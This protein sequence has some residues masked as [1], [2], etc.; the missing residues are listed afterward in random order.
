MN[1]VEYNK[2][3]TQVL[4]QYNILKKSF[5]EEEILCNYIG[6]FSQDIL[7]S[8]ISLTEHALV[9]SAA[10]KTVKNRL[11]NIIIECV[12]NIIFHNNNLPDNSQLAFIIVTSDD[13]GFKVYAT[14]TIL[15]NKITD[16][17]DKV[18]VLMKEKKESLMSLISKKMKNP[19][20]I[21]KGHGRIGLMTILTKSGKN[22]QYIIDKLSEN[23]A[24]FQLKINVQF[25]DYN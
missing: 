3:E 20:A 5:G 8:I 1:K 12:Q 24:L 15:N 25:K 6:K 14:N 16:L 23:Y 10:P 19:E 17:Q 18:E 9:Q 21:S 4:N 2:I 13:E 7:I 22:F 11:L